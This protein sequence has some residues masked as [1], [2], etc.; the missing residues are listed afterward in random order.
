[1]VYSDTLRAA[2]QVKR[3]CERKWIKSGLAVHHELYKEQC[4]IYSDIV[5]NSKSNYHRHQISECNQRSLFRVIDKL[6]SPKCLKKLPSFDNPVDLANNFAS[7]FEDKI[8]KLY[9]RFDNNHPSPISVD[10]HDHCTSSFATFR[11]VTSD[12]VMKMI[13]SCSIT[14]CSWTLCH[15]L[16]LRSVILNCCQS[17]Q[18]LLID[19]CLLVISLIILRRLASCHF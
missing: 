5:N 12:E 14:S 19:L 9:G 3:R 13:K 18:R 1:M 17:S 11:V 15:Y 4:I 16:F 7:F 6:S 8:K 2:K 10:I